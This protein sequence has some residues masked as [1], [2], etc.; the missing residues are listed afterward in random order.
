MQD[1]AAS[2]AVPLTA[3]LLGCLAV[4]ALIAL[5]LL[6]YVRHSRRRSAAAQQLKGKALPIT[7]TA[8]TPQQVSARLTVCWLSMHL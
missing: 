8:G 3:S 7:A 5:A 2:L 4:L 1:S 6:L